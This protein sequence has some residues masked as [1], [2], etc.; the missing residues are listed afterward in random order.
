MEREISHGEV[1]LSSEDKEAVR[2]GIR[3][4]YAGVA[5]TPEGNFRY[6]TG[7][8]GLEALRYP[9]EILEKLPESV[10]ASYC[11]VG[12]PFSLGPV[13]RGDLVLDVGCGA[14]VDTL[15]AAIMTGASGKAAGVDLVEHMLAKARENL[16]RTGLHNVRFYN[17]SGEELPFEDKSFDLVISNGAFN[18]IVEKAKAI[19]EAFRVLKPNGRLMIADQVLTGV[20]PNDAKSIVESWSK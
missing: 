10:V 1:P 16:E 13:R 6:P 8:A 14:G 17:A 5:I 3:R 4:K 2:A 20:Q 12:N 9:S 11:G 15:V 19:E 18:L 7:R